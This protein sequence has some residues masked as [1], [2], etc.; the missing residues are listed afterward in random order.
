M[1]ASQPGTFLVRDCEKNAGDFILSVRDIDKVRH[2]QIV[3]LDDDDGE[4]C[5][6]LR[7]PF[8]S[9][10]DLIL[11]YSQQADGLCGILKDPCVVL[12]QQRIIRRWEISRD[13]I[14]FTKM[15]ELC[16]YYEVWQ[17]EW[18]KTPV[19]IRMPGEG[20]VCIA[21]FYE[22]AEVMKQLKHDN[23]IKFYGICTQ[24]N[25]LCITE[26]TNCGNLWTYLKEK[27][28]TLMNCDLLDMG[29]Q[30]ASAMHYLEGKR[31]VHRN[32]QA[33]NIMLHSSNTLVCKVANFTYAKI[34]SEHDYVESTVQEKFPIKWTAPESLRSKRFTIKSDAWSFGIVLYELITCGN[35]P[36]PCLGSRDKN[37]LLAQL[38][39]GYRMSCPV[40]CPEELHEIMMECWKRDADDRPT[41]ET[42]LEKLGKLV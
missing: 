27:G 9:I 22:E 6:S 36:Y 15:V 12:M 20:F 28:Y 11:H 40:A 25:P 23:I 29:V 38:D 14:H 2:Y 17:G 30:I 32:L 42:I 37:K 35:D 7:Q 10:P 41:F 18:Y 13:N 16:E 24:K 21:K 33:I 39:T 1:H 34:I 4:F 19:T 26:L 5:I 8:K 31:C 3:S